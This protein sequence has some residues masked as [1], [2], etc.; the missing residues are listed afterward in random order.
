MDKALLK[1]FGNRLEKTPEGKK[2][3]QNPMEGVEVDYYFMASRF[4]GSKTQVTINLWTVAVDFDGNIYG[5]YT[6]HIGHYGCWKEMISCRIEQHLSKLGVDSLQVKRMLRDIIIQKE[7][8]LIP[9]D[10]RQGGSRIGING[11]DELY[12][13]KEKFSFLK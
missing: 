8:H 12:I 9:G 5:M 4:G 3:I 13:R 1:P 11:S 7:G 2:V 10:H 6:H